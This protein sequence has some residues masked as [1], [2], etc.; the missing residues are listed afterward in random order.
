MF[1]LPRGVGC[2][3]MTTIM[4][5]CLLQVTITFAGKEIPKSPY[6]VLV[7]GAAGDPEKVTAEGPGLE[8]TG[9]QAGK[10]TYFEVFT[11]GRI[12]DSIS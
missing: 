7:E 8:S 5:Q 11:E 10:K 3:K 9:V 2:L 1:Y 4:R 6:L 12:D